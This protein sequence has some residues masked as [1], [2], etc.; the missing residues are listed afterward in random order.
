MAIK[1]V[2]LGYSS[3]VHVMRWARGM[4]DKGFEISVISLGGEEID[5][6]PTM[7]LPAGEIRSASYITKV[8]EVKKIIE[9]IKPDLVHS[10]Y[11]AGFGF[12]GWR[13]QFH[14]HLISVW[15]ADIIDFPNNFIKR[16]FVRKILCS[17]DYL[18][19]TSH[20]LKE[21]TVALCPE[22]ESLIE[23]VPFGVEIPKSNSDRLQDNKTRL[24]YIKA[25]RKKYGPDILL[26]AL[27]I[28]IEKVNNVHLTVAGSGEL[29]G[30]L[31]MLTKELGLERHVTF[32]GFVQN[33][34]IAQLLDKHD[35]MVMP[36]I[37]ESESFG[38]AVLEASAAGL[39]VIATNIG[40]VPEVL[41]DRETG[42]LVPPGDVSALAGAII[43]LAE[44]V[45]LREQM[46]RRGK[47]FCA[48][49]YRWE[50]CLDRMAG[51][52]RNLITGEGRI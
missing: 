27:R 30:R 16:A 28:V 25:H 45:R 41:A 19:A 18:S 31:K 34:K 1:V 13:S 17:A 38:V 47:E 21:R 43:R 5:G 12:W 40:G 46:G 2:I 29:T 6:V 51:I 52:Y 23:V 32:T 50:E 44:D 7:V 8:F 49:K 33:E 3:S 24:V 42:I 4:A 22:V 26:K 9:N 39:P 11:A 20:F 14:P 15:G 48:D 37:M 10:H 35:I 36:S